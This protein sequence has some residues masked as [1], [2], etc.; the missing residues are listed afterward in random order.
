MKKLLFTAAL[1]LPFI[2]YAQIQ[3]IETNRTHIGKVECY[4][5]TTITATGDTARDIIFGFRNEVYEIINDYQVILI[6]LKNKNDITVFINDLKQATAPMSAKGTILWDRENYL[7]QVYD[8]TEKISLG[9]PRNSQKAY[10]SI[11]NKQA[12]KIINWLTPLID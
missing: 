11:T 9:T 3:R 4:K 5:S 10:V 8:W 7:I 6:P 12:E 1:L 2:V